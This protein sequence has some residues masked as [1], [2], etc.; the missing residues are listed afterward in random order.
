MNKHNLKSG[1]LFA[2]SIMVAGFFT[3]SG[4]TQVFA[5]STNSPPTISYS[6]D[7]GYINDGINPDS[8]FTNTNF[9][10][11]IVY[12]DLD[13]DPPTRIRTVVFDGSPSDSPAIEVSSDVMTLDSSA[14]AILRDGN[15]TNGEQYALTKSFPAGIYRYRWEWSDGKIPECGSSLCYMI[16]D[17]IAGGREQSFTVLFG[18]SGGGGGGSGDGG[19][20]SLPIDTDG[21]GLLD[22]WETQDIDTSGD[23]I[24]DLSLSQ[25]V[26]FDGTTNPPDPKRKDIYVW[27]DWLEKTGE[28][29][30]SHK[31]DVKAL[32][33]VKEAFDNAPVENG[34]AIEGINLHIVL[35]NAIE[36][37]ETYVE[38]GK[39]FEN[40]GL[41]DDSEFNTLK[42][43]SLLS[44]G[45]RP[46]MGK[47]FH[48]AVY[49]HY[50][51]EIKATCPNRTFRPAG[52]GGFSGGGDLIIGHQKLVDFNR[53][54]TLEQGG[55]FM[56]ELGHTLGLGHGGVGMLNST[57]FKPNHL[58][59]MNYSFAKGLLY[60]QDGESE[61]SRSILDYSRFDSSTIPTLNEDNLNEL[62]GLNSSPTSVLGRYGTIY[63]RDYKDSVDGVGTIVHNA[64]GAIDWNFN[65]SFDTES[66]KANING[67]TIPVLDAF[68][69]CLNRHTDL[70]IDNEWRGLNYTRGT[71]GFRLA[72][73]EETAG[74]S[75][76]DF[77]DPAED[78]FSAA[79]VAIKIDIKPGSDTN[80]VNYHNKNNII[81]VA[82]V[83]T[84]SFDALQID[85][86]T[87]RF[88]GATEVHRDQTGTPR[89]HE[90]D[91]NGDG[92]KD[93]VLH[94]RLGDTRITEETKVGILT[95]KTFGGLIVSGKDA[96]RLIA[97]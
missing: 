30:H 17:G 58:S 55:V 33:L 12:T 31:P 72:S 67:D 35:G 10:F 46:G 92:K 13:N 34:G 74:E 96:I 20:G 1:L 88:E 8:G 93:L 94:F 57:N 86:T 81:P 71:V 27:V 29:A 15:Y 54:G 14:N 49:G 59:V 68:S 47:V 39:V 44:N 91:V 73:I 82:V 61:P 65:N 40:L 70:S 97:K 21:D 38:I 36:E 84:G 53:L 90:E 32:R 24:P 50:L 95:A 66:V 83:S 28:D 11:K 89:R 75:L 80:P 78:M 52:I 7:A 41:Y 6:P 79:D 3:I 62:V 87:V 19:G 76:F 51:P 85:H 42:N 18:S 4:T 77:A 56:H 23:G 69:L 5:I 2:A 22:I 43:F 45:T 64:N 48:Y 25:L 63:Y 37:T 60:K 26:E 16:S 9:I